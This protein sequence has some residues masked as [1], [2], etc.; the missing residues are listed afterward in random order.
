[1]TLEDYW[2]GRDKPYAADLTSEIE[3]NAA[4][5]VGR[6]NLLAK[7]LPFPRRVCRRAGDRRA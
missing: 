6:C 3:Q 1:M 4:D 7:E 2:M 5:L